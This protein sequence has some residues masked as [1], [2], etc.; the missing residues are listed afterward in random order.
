M[1]WSDLICAHSV[2]GAVALL[3]VLARF[4]RIRSSSKPEYVYH[5]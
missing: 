4:D 1:I 3:A 5:L 2:F